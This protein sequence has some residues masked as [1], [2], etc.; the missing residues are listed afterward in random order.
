MQENRSHKSSIA[1][2]S[3]V[4]DNRADAKSI[5]T[6]SNHLNLT[7]DNNIDGKEIG[8]ITVQLNEG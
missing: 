3:A 1:S 4:G 8:P 7:K 2:K 5:R 6:E